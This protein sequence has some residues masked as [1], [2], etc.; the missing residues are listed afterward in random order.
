MGTCLTIHLQQ[1]AGAYR[2]DFQFRF[3]NST[4]SVNPENLE[5]NI[6]GVFVQTLKFTKFSPKPPTFI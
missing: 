1:W 4:I 6:L 2:E 3:V 5:I